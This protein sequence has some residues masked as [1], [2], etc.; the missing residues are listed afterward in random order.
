MST[1]NEEFPSDDDAIDVKAE[2][3]AE[4]PAE[5]PKDEG[6]ESLPFQAEV[7][8]VLTLVINSLYTNKEVFL[9]ELVSNAADALDKGR[10]FQLTHEDAQK[11][12]GEPRIQITANEKERTL[13]IED[14]GIG[15]TRDEVI[16]NLGTIARSGSLE[17]LKQH[18]EAAKS[19]DAALSIIGQF[20][21]GFYA[22]FMV[23]RRVDVKTR[24]MKAGSEPVVWR[25]SGEGSFTVAPG[26]RETPGT[27]IVLHLKEDQL[28]F[29][30]AWRLKDIITKYSDYVSVPI[31]VDGE[32]A[33]Q[34][35]ALWAMPR[36]SITEEQHSAFYKHITGG[37]VGDSPLI[38]IHIAVDAPVQFQALLYVPEKAPF[39]L[40]QKDRTA[41]RLYAKRVLIMESCE[42]LTPLYLRFL[43][44]VVDSEDLS[45]NVS[46]EVLQE[47]R[48]L[49][50]IE[51][52]IV[53]QVFKTLKDVAEND[54]DKYKKFWNLFGKLLKE[55]ITL[56]W[57][58]KDTIAELARFE[59]L[60]TKEGDLISL[61]QYVAAMPSDQRD[62]YYM[63][64]PNRRAIETSP[65]LEAFRKKKY[66][67]LLL[68]D[69]IDEWV[70]QA[71][72]DF[73]KLKLK[74]VAHGD[75]DLGDDD[76]KEEKPEPTDA[77][78]AIKKTLG[79]RVKDVRFSKRLTDTASCLVSG[80]GDPGANMERIL[81]MMD[82][83]AQEKKRILEVNPTH[84]IVENI[85]KLAAKEPESP[86]T[87]R[88]A[89]STT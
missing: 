39:D 29:A 82:E 26:D 46:R 25:S 5:L 55:G 28:D 10:F 6:A 72:T 13:T 86:S 17:F 69:P 9:R 38:T 12:V 45:L 32:V 40:F 2:P 54:P 31:Y 43:R 52:Q 14:N 19:K 35:K 11:Q 51:Q 76:K 78:T 21:V 22:A 3:V 85:A 75:L 80:E 66:D 48:T 84:P 68:T 87:S 8:K 23:A 59:A 60:S 41:L 20:G 18:G 24:S 71:L 44:G 42:K 74:S 65:H 56:D 70:V 77:L 30:R 33:N 53:K 73:E 36:A 16:Q 67:V 61:K 37:T 7:Q 83:R 89:G 58:H 62:I 50:L 57:K 47:S 81:R 34:S 64:G 15:M 27:E 88:T 79:D 1:E 49:T 4:A 63:T